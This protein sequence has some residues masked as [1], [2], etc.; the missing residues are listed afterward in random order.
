MV[1]KDGRWV[2]DFVEFEN[3]LKKGPGVFL[4]CNPHNPGGTVFNGDEIAR[5]IDLC[6]QYDCMILSD[7][8]HADI[9]LQTTVKHISIGK[10]LPIDFPAITFFATSKTYNTAGMGGAV[11]IIPNVEIREKFIKH[12][13]GIFPMLSRHSIEIIQTSLTMNHIWLDSLLVYLRSNHDF[14]FSFINKMSCLKMLPL[15]AT[16]LAWIQYDSNILGD[17]QQRLFNNGLHVLRGEQFLGKNFIRVNIACTKK[18]LDKAMLIIK[19]TID[20]TH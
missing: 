6:N 12:S 17:F 3:Q 2:Y 1:E 15:E 5:I 16:Y 8:I 11:A 9:L 18:S 4:F 20:E 13:Q 7:E 19:K 14:L 10:Y